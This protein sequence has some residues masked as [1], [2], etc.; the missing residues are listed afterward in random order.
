M[1][2]SYSEHHP[3]SLADI[4]SHGV[5][6]YIEIY[7]YVILYTFQVLPLCIHVYMHVYMSTYICDVY[8]GSNPALEHMRMYILNIC[9]P[10]DME[11]ACKA[12]NL[13]VLFFVTHLQKIKEILNVAPS[14][15]CISL[16]MFL[17]C[18]W[19]CT[20]FESYVA[21]KT[22]IDLHYVYYLPEHTQFISH[23]VPSYQAHAQIS[24]C[25]LPPRNPNPNPSYVRHTNN[26]RIEFRPRS[27]NFLVSVNTGTQN[28]L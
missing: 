9:P 4:A 24:S 3:F 19:E 15:G 11:K 10:N 1:Y 26:R 17:F 7:I 14:D 8:V 27:G 13:A 28:R 23:Q 5:S 12:T 16:Y 21:K 25:A 2:Q 6:I 20:I 18:F 22:K